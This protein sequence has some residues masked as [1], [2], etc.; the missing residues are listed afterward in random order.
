LSVLP[1]YRRFGIASKLLEEAIKRAKESGQEL[2]SVF[3]HTPENNQL[4]IDF[5]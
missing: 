5:Y 1:A 3:L 2:Y 4:A